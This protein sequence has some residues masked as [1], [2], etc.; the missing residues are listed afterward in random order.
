LFEQPTDRNIK[1][2]RQLDERGEA[3]IL[4]TPFDRPSK[5]SSE[6]TLVGELLLGPF[7]LPAKHPNADTKAFADCIGVLHSSMKSG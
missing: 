3:K 4:L 5:R 6:T 2:I 1:G 7:A